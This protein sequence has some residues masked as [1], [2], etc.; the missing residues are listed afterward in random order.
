[1]HARD[2]ELNSKLGTICTPVEMLAPDDKPRKTLGA[3]FF[4]F[5]SCWKVERLRVIVNGYRLENI[6]LVCKLMK[7]WVIC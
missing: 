7:R 5:M 4:V 6:K 1:M 3:D 2:S